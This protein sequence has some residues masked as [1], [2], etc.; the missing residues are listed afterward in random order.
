MEFWRCD[1]LGVSIG[2]LKFEGG[3]AVCLL[4]EVHKARLQLL[5]HIEKYITNSQNEPG[6]QATS[7]IR[8]N[9][10][11]NTLKIITAIIK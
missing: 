8:H 7:I 3:Q 11:K 2:W 4:S 10:E 9:R 6:D 1:K 5:F